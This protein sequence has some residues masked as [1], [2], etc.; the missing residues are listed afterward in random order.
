MYYL[1][2]VFSLK[3]HQTRLKFDIEDNC[4]ENAVPAC[5]G[6]LTQCPYS[7]QRAYTHRT[8]LI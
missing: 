6:G 4:P 3:F 2:P 5:A 7:I 1:T 8:L